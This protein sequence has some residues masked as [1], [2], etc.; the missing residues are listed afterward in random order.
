MAFD[1]GV[2]RQ[3]GALGAHPALQI[4]EQRRNVQR[5][6][7]EPFERRPAV[8]LTF[9][10]EDRIDALHRLERHRRDDGERAARLGGDVGE[11]EE[12]APCMRPAG[13]LGDRTSLAIRLV[14]P[15]E[16][17]IA[18]GLQ[19]AA[20]AVQVT[21]GMF[22]GAVARVE[23]H[24]GWRIAAAE[25]TIVAHID[26]RAAQSPFAPWRAPAPESRRHARA[27][28]R[29]RA[30]GSGRTAAAAAQHNRPPGRRASTG[31]AR[32]PRARSAP[33]GG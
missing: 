23:E 9:D 7:G 4:R 21:L 5:A 6:L 24:G 29:A 19:D 14:E 16:A 20:I 33:T 25:R 2:P 3:P 32:R 18:I 31:S 8:D 13:C 26:P 12:L 22:V 1:F 17:G 30:H 15:V 28:R 27:R 10:V 11:H